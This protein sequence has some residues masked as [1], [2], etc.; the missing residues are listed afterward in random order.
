MAQPY[1]SF[2]ELSNRV[3]DRTGEAIGAGIRAAGASAGKILA[4]YRQAKKNDLQGIIDPEKDINQISNE[5]V[6]VA[7]TN[8]YEKNFK[9]KWLPLY[10]ENRARFTPEQKVEMEGDLA[11]LQ[12][13]AEYYNQQLKSAQAARDE[14]QKD[15]NVRFNEE[16]Y[17]EF[18]T[19]LVP[20]EDGS[21]DKDAVNKALSKASKSDTGVPF[22]EYRKQDSGAMLDNLFFKAADKQR[23]TGT[24][25][26]TTVEN[27]KQVT[28]ERSVYA[29]VRTPK[30]QM[31]YVIDEHN[32]LSP[33]EQGAYEADLYDKMSMEEQQAAHQLFKDSNTPLTDYQISK[34]V[35]KDQ[36]RIKTST[37]VKPESTGS[38]K[39]KQVVEK[40]ER[41]WS[42]GNNVV[43]M[44][45]EIKYYDG[46]ELK[47]K[48]FSNARINGITI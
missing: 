30:E 43:R 28:K 10:Q 12:R 22:L 46:D 9:G 42:F 5:A 25:K 44:D 40:T 29:P 19:S 4:D 17:D 38:G 36:E 39:K 47:T 24:E 8:D 6:R 48:T 2:S 3:P 18:I 27:G 31:A 16:A 14:A 33:R 15:G 1:L 7:L 26:Y 32:K 11:N 23:V 45:K 41:G 37:T 35:L 21:Y 20:K 13:T 34:R